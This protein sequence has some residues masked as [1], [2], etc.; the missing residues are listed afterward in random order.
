MDRFNLAGLCIAIS[1]LIFATLSYFIL[2]NTPLTAIGISA[3][4]LGFSIMITPMNPLPP[5]AV[6]SMLEEVLASNEVILEWLNVGSR[7]YYTVCDDRRVYVYVPLS[8]GG[9][10][11]VGKP[12]GL[13]FDDR[14]YSYLAL[15]S[16]VSGLVGFKA[17]GS[18]ESMLEYILVDLT[19]LCESVSIVETSGGYTVEFRKPRSPKPPARVGR[20]LGSLETCIAASTVALAT[21][22]PVSIV[23]EEDIDGRRVAILEVYG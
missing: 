17:T 7:G 18:L 12:R 14:G 6:R 20:V 9:P 19:E 16:P 8:G 15:P 21:G 1:G 3:V 23:S 13:I 10:P 4:I 5:E 11:R 2:A 22:R